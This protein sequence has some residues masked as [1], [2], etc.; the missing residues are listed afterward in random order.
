MYLGCRFHI[1]DEDSFFA[2]AQRSQIVWECLSRVRY[3]ADDAAKY[4]TGW[5]AI[6]TLVVEVISSSK[7][8]LY[9]EGIQ[10]LL[11]N[12]T[13]AAAYPLHD[14][15]LEGFVNTKPPNLRAVLDLLLFIDWNITFVL[16]QVLYNQWAQFRRWY[17]IQPI[18]YIKTYFGE[19]RMADIWNHVVTVPWWFVGRGFLLDVLCYTG[20]C[21]CLEPYQLPRSAAKIVIPCLRMKG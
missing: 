20:C 21:V 19:V 1:A 3:N 18:A 8:A 12:G 2:P 9:L 10:R 6:F 7:F 5:V 17:K 16:C 11:A 15:S 4:G 14:G 13:F